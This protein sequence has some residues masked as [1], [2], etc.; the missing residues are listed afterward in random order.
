MKQVFVDIEF[1]FLNTKEKTNIN[2]ANVVYFAKNESYGS[3]YIKFIDGEVRLITKE[4]YDK[5]MLT[6][7]NSLLVE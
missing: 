6:S 4:S 7:R 3:Y 5:L 1:E 2:L